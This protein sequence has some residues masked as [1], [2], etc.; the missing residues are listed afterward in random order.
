MS[1]S[2]FDVYMNVESAKELWDSFESKYMADDSSSKKFFDFKHALKHGKDDLSLVQL[3]SHLRIDES[4]R[5]QDSEKGNGSVALEFS[6]GKTV[7]L[8]NVLYVPKLRKNLV[9]SPMLN[10]HGYKQVYEY[11]KYI[12]SKSGVFVGFGYYNNG[13]FMLNLNKVHDDS[14]S[15]YM[16][17]STIAL[18]HARLGYVYYKRMLEMSKDDLIPVIDENLEKCTTSPYTPQQ[19]GVA[20]RKNRAL[21]EMVNSMLSYSSLSEGF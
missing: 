21:K 9:S 13:M 7:T 8:F 15:A 6:S 1:N 5:A 18:C 10:K 11:D 3:G 19:N 16:S 12:L 2:L 4:L 14:D 20:E 17:S